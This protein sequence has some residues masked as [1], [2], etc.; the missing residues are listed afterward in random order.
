MA[1]YG[2]LTTELYALHYAP[3]ALK[4]IKQDRYHLVFQ[5]V[6]DELTKPQFDK[7]KTALLETVDYMLTHFPD[8]LNIN[9]ETIAG[10][11]SHHDEDALTLFFKAGIDFKSLDGDEPLILKALMSQASLST[12]EKLIAHGCQVEPPQ[13]PNC[14]TWCMTIKKPYAFFDLIAKHST[15]FHHDPTLF[16][17]IVNAVALS[18][19]RN[20]RGT[21]ATSAL[22]KNYLESLL[23]YGA[24]P[25]LKSKT[26]GASAYEL[27]KNMGAENLTALFDGYINARQAR[28]LTTS[29]PALLAAQTDCFAPFMDKLV[30]TGQK[31]DYPLLLERAPHGFHALDLLCTRGTLSALFNQSYWAKDDLHAFV[32]AMPRY[33]HPALQSEAEKFENAR[34]VAIL[35]KN[36]SPFKL[37]AKKI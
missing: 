9:A 10:L 8:R 28:T 33:L 2:M 13:K 22:Y 18:E 15:F 27:A 20:N 36:P 1:I 16:I 17:T 34:A 3:N 19:M 31:L 11:F 6:L 26:V 29:N 5:E 37:K 35:K 23:N 21:T 7:I 14:L 4:S 30:H 12:I 25:H 24:D 32:C